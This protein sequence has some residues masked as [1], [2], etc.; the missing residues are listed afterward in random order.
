MINDNAKTLVVALRSDQYLQGRDLLHRKTLDGREQ[1]CCL[2]VACDLYVKAGSPNGELKREWVKLSD[3]ARNQGHK[4]EYME[5]NGNRTVTSLP[6]PVRAWLNFRGVTGAFIP[7]T[8]TRRS[9]S[10]SELNDDGK[11][12]RQIADLIESEPENLFVSK[13]ALIE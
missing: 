9:C 12:F 7:S 13:S 4:L 11:T 8:G 2:G 3:A 10:L 1:L 5:L 6:E